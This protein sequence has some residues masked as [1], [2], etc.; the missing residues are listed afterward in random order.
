[1]CYFRRKSMCKYKLT[2]LQMACF[3]LLCPVGGMGGILSYLLGGGG[4]EGAP[5]EPERPLDWDEPELA[6][7]LTP[8]HK[9]A[10]KESWALVQPEMR[11]T[12]V[13]LLIA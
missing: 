9:F 7:G 10:V 5:A 4:Q 13:A 11:A 8:H 2:K 12:G 1:M 3:Q 6:T